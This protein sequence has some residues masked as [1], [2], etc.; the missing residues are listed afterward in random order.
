[1]VGH[2]HATNQRG[3]VPSRGDHQAELDVELV[4]RGF[5]HGLGQDASVAGPGN[6]LFETCSGY[7]LPEVVQQAT[8]EG[9]LGVAFAPVRERSAQHRAGHAP[10]PVAPPQLGKAASDDG[11]RAD[12]GGQRDLTDLFRSDTGDCGL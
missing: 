2:D 7:H 12:G 9:F 8:N 5:P 3:Q 10:A 6:D 11:V 4:H 1:M